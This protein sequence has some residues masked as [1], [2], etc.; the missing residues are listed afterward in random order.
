M[1]NAKG[2]GAKHFKDN[3]GDPK[4]GVG[5]T[6]F[7]S[8]REILLLKNRTKKIFKITE[9][10]RI[11]G[12]GPLGKRVGAKMGEEQ[13]KDEKKGGDLL[14][15]PKLCRRRK[16]SGRTTQKAVYNISEK[17][18]KEILVRKAGKKRNRVTSPEQMK[19]E[20]SSMKPRG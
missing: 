8:E 2:K 7:G 9:P 20:R 15:E 10:S 5:G 17:K 18:K 6:N 19:V 12:A 14:L 16:Q 4:G 1:A 3:S 11:N 13:P